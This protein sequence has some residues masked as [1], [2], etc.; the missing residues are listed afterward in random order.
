MRSMPKEKKDVLAIIYGYL[1]CGWHARNEK[2]FNKIDSTPPKVANN[3]IIMA[4]NLVKF[5][6]ILVF[7][8]GQIGFVALL[9]FRKTNVC[10]VCFF[11]P[12]LLS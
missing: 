3:I 7:V 5:R 8:N 9:L 1:W 4:F 6:A 2:L 10:F 12:A 11:C